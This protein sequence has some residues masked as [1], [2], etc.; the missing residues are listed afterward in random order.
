M[1]GSVLAAFLTS[2]L[3]H[4]AAAA[5]APLPAN[6]LLAVRTQTNLTSVTL[7]VYIDVLDATN[8]S[9][10][11][12]IELPTAVAGAQLRL[13][14][15]QSTVEGAL[16]ISGDGCA[17]VL[18]GYDAPPGVKAP[19]LDTTIT[20][21]VLL[22]R[23]NGTLDTRTGHLGIAT[24]SGIPR[25]AAMLPDATVIIAGDAG[26]MLPIAA[27]TVAPATA[28]ATLL[29]S[30]VRSLAAKPP[31]TLYYT[32]A[33]Q[34]IPMAP[35]AWLANPN[36]EPLNATLPGP[37]RQLGSATRAQGPYGFAVVDSNTV[38][39]ADETLG[40]LVYRYD[41]STWTTTQGPTDPEGADPWTGFSHATFDPST[42][43]VYVSTTWRSASDRTTRIYVVAH[44]AQWSP[45]SL[46]LLLLTRSPAGFEYRGLAPTPRA[47]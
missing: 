4:T 3:V 44:D 15:R 29:S 37:G 41:G 43:Q 28:T 14:L 31:A 33:S 13:T 40:L 1:S 47:C 32:S 36:G 2:V 45:A 12:S 20:R 38:V 19:Q 39:A 21:S 11:A 46:Q 17:V 25:S 42:G 7:P 18:A 35:G 27:G 22:L 9:V 23:A 8:G 26:V 24:L 10:L 30:N 34:V 5:I 16:T 6:A